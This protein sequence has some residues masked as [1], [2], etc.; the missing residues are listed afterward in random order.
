MT[1]TA[2]GQSENNPKTHDT[3][4][5]KTEKNLSVNDSEPRLST[6]IVTLKVV[7]KVSYGDILCSTGGSKRSA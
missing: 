7:L 6:A 1:I 4:E 5:G 2:L 3:I